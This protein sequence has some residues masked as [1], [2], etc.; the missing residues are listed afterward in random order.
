MSGDD[1]SS[2]SSSSNSSNSRAYSI[3]LLKQAFK[4]Y[5]FNH[6]HLVEAPDAI[7]EREFGYS[8]FD[9]TMVRHLSMR[10]RR[11]LVALLMVNV[12]ADMYC[13]TA[14]YTSPSRPMEEKGLK[15]ADLIFDIDIKELKPRCSATHDIRICEECSEEL[16]DQSTACGRC[17]SSR[18]NHVIMPC[19][20]C[21]SLGKREVK[22]LVEILVDDFGVDGEGDDGSGGI[23]VYFSGNYGFHVYV[24][25][26]YTTLDS[27][28]RREIVD[29]MLGRGLMDALTRRYGRRGRKGAYGRGRGRSKRRS[30]G[31]RGRGVGTNDAGYSDGG[32]EVGG[33]DPLHIPASILAAEGYGWMGRIGRY[34]GA[35]RVSMKSVEDA[36][37]A[38]SVKVDPNVTMD[39]HRIFRLPG[40]L[41]SKSS[42]AK[43]PLM[44]SEIDSFDPFED[45]CF[46]SD[47]EVGVHV[48]RAPRFTLK[49]NVFGPYAHEDVKLPLYAAS[50]LICK[51]LA[52]V[53]QPPA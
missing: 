21:I 24:K 35:E 2:S 22:K 53:K 36:I 29:Y 30:M 11:E 43:V 46:I 3:N 6:T 44:I 48:V 5:Y 28:A 31:G 9:G 1:G 16:H 49:D 39:M 37:L 33:N 50:Y 47:R 25:G 12:P 27:A 41:N 26:R 32:E 42:L 18:V 17:G 20:E 38:L 8:R 15:G 23:R 7:Q 19:N 10:D 40:T 13:S 45:A 34:L 14:Y 52:Y 4:E 51:G